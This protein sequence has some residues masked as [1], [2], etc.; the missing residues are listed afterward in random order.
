MQDR[1]YSLNYKLFLED[2]KYKKHSQLTAY[3]D[4]MQNFYEGKQMPQ[5]EVK[6][7]PKF[8][9]NICAFLV[10][11]KASKIIGTPYSIVHQSANERAMDMLDKFDRFVL[12]DM[13]YPVGLQETVQNMLIYGTAIEY[14]RFDGNSVAFDALYEGKLVREHVDVRRF[15]VANPYLNSLQK[16]KWVMYWSYFDVSAVKEMC[17]RKNGETEKEY[18]ARKNSIVRDDYDENQAKQDPQ[19]IQH[20]VCLVFTRFF[21]VNGEVVYQSSTKE[22]DLFSPRYLSPS[23]QEKVLVEMEKKFNKSAESERDDTKVRDYEGMDPEVP[24]IEAQKDKMTSK[25]YQEKLSKF[26]LYPFVDFALSRRFNHFYGI[27]DIQDYISAQQVVNYLY[28]LSAKNIQDNAWGKWIVKAGALNGQKIN[29]NGGQVLVDYSRGNDWGIKR[30]E[31]N[32]GNMVNVCEYINNI[33]SVIRTLSGSTEAITGENAAQLSGYAI[34]LLQEQG[35]TVFEMVQQKIWNGNAI[36][37][38][39]IRLQFYIHYYDKKMHFIYE[40]D[41]TEF[42]KEQRAR[43][44][45]IDRDLARYRAEAQTN[46]NATPP[47]LEDYPQVTHF[48]EREFDVNEI[49]NEKFYIVPKAGRGIKY[50]EVVQADQINQLFK[51]GAISK[52]S[53]ADKKAYIDLNPLLDETTKAK[54]MHILEQE[55]ESQNAILTQ[56]VQQLTQTL[57]DK[58][59]MITAMQQRITAQAEYIKNLTGQFKN[60]LN[61]ANEQNKI[62]QK[63]LQAKADA[64]SSSSQST[65]TSASDKLLQEGVNAAIAQ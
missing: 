55:A 4:Q 7:L 45:K 43:D 28:T 41:D 61:A 20:G 2:E 39:K 14:Y 34:S 9:A 17:K 57:Q 22:V 6:G 54:Y 32:S 3:W 12:T 19:Y 48:Q 63:A 33:I 27:S 36:D 15:A 50:S 5:V 64:T 56:Q 35:N 29:N 49:K 23:A 51:D 60:S 8:I 58:D 25:E 65:K 11:T 1:E 47:K 31:A 38:A 42:I 40:L 44:W 62:Y 13:Q 24:T 10:R 59:M 30:V 37:E 52:L 16:Q 53:A 46:P 18:E 21:R 26:S